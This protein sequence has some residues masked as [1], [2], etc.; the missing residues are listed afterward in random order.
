MSVRTARRW[1][2]IALVISL[3]I[4]PAAGAGCAT[5]KALANP[6]A[7]SAAVEDAGMGVVVRRADAAMDV[8]REVDRLLVSTP[9]DEGSAWLA[10]VHLDQASADAAMDEAG[11]RAV[12]GAEPAR[13]LPAEAWAW[14]LPKVT[15]DG[16]GHA[17]VLGMI[18]AQ[19]ADEYKAMQDKGKGYSEATAK[20]ADAQAKLEDRADDLDP[21]TREQ[22]NDEIDDLKAQQKTAREALLTA[23]RALAKKLKEGCAKVSPSL[24]DKL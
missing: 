16:G 1:M 3:G 7:T 20:V 17:S 4:V 10:K 18:S 15:S 12:Y 19:A 9:V 2:R 24:R 8:S 23:A 21:I 14:V 5:L 22:R 6:K 13:I 11:K